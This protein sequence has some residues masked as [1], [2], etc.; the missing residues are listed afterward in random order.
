MHHSI[1]S[2]VLM[3]LLVIAPSLVHAAPMAE[4][5]D[6]VQTSR[7]KVTAMIAVDDEAVQGAL[8]GEIAAI[9]QDVNA[10]A[11]A[12]LV[13]EATPEDEK[14]KLTEFKMIWDQ[15]VL[16]RDN[17]MIPAI[18]AGDKEKAKA[19]GQDVQADRFKK[20]SGLLK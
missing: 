17:E 20:I 19:I 2:F 14:A 6:A 18:L 7:Q 1:R 4:L 13:D 5:F 16:T 8:I 10:R 3:A 12:M 11:D 15:L 9:T